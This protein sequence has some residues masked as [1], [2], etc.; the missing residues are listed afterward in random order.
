LKDSLDS[1]WISYED[2]NQGYVKVEFAAPMP[3]NKPKVEAL[4]SNESSMSDHCRFAQTVLSM[5]PV[6]GFNADFDVV[7]E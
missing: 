7:V 3:P 1:D 6:E 5:P 4:V 2:P